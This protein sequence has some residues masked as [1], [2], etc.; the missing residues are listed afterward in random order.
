MSDT[1]HI[2]EDDESHRTIC[3]APPTFPA[4]QGR[5]FLC[6]RCAEI[7]RG[8]R[9]GQTDPP[10]KRMAQAFVGSNPTPRSQLP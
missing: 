9:S 8:Y 1:A 6:E 7:M 3:G 5:V 4:E 2:Y 10:A